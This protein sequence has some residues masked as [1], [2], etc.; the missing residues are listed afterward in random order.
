MKR[1][2]VALPMLV[3]VDWVDSGTSH[4]W[5]N[6]DPR[7][8]REDGALFCRT[9]GYLVSKNANSVRIAASIALNDESKAD[10]HCCAITIPRFAIRRMKR[11]PAA[12]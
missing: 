7:E 6:Y 1:R 2:R 10:S 11:L 5:R 4:G 3:Y 8:A 12:E 9:V